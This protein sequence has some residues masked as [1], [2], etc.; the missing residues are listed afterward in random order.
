M[1][2]SEGRLLQLQAAIGDGDAVQ[3]GFA[4]VHRG[5]ESRILVILIGGFVLVIALL[6]LDGFVGFHGVTSVRQSLYTLTRNQ[7]L[8][9]ALIDEVQQVESAVDFIERQA[10]SDSGASPGQQFKAAVQEVEGTLRKL[11]AQ[12]DPDYPAKEELREVGL[13]STRLA[14]VAGQILALPAGSKADIAELRGDRQRL[15]AAVTKFILSSHRQAEATRQQVDESTRRQS[16]EDRLL[17]TC[18]LLIA[19]FFLW[20]AIRIYYRMSEQ[21][22]E[23]QRVSWQ[24]LEKQESL[25]RRLSRELHDELGQCLTAL[26]T[27][28]SRHAGSACV[29][30]RWM[31]D[32]TQLLKESIQSAHEISQLLRPTLLDDFGLD[33]ALAWLCERFEERQRIHVR[34]ESDFP[35]RLEEQAE[36]HIFRIAQ[37]ALT[38]VARHAEASGVHVSFF[39]EANV[40][41]LRIS[42]D[43]QGMVLERE[44]GGLTFGLTGMKAR[45]R[46]LEGNMEIRSAP[47][48]GTLIDVSFPVR[49]TLREEC[50]PHLVS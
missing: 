10:S 49:S 36:T 48:Q 43:G 20:I 37:E 32:C 1:R 11:H 6:G 46:S 28:F 50:H 35:H 29:D 47:G 12:L 22:Q 17:L 23:L 39:R 24:L 16:I 15:S 3:P 25:A 34:Y 21:S 18:C 40:A 2:T 27:N 26:K 45:A 42:D 33:S 38:N 8:E 13:A 44:A 19:C 41:R 31:Q 30:T 7:L 14:S 4:P 5:S 9:S